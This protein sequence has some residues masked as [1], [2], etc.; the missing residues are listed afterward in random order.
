[1]TRS[2]KLS[3]WQNE[4]AAASQ[5]ELTW[6]K[7]FGGSFNSAKSLLRKSADVFDGFAL[8]VVKSRRLQAKRLRV[9]AWQSSATTCQPPRILM[10]A[11]C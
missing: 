1:M 9:K 8:T 4:L 3:P 2:F 6:S 5:L 7:S 10:A 11:L